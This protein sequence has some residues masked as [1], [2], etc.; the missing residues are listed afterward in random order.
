MYI[1]PK[2]YVDLVAQ[3]RVSDPES[4]PDYYQPQEPYYEPLQPVVSKPG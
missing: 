3:R 4:I 1:K 2:S